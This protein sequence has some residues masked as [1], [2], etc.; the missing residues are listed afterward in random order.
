MADGLLR[1]SPKSVGIHCVCVLNSL[2]DKILIHGRGGKHSSPKIDLSFDP[3][4]CLLVVDLWTVG[5][6]VLI[7]LY[8]LFPLPKI[9]SHPSSCICRQDKQSLTQ[10][11]NTESCP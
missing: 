6:F 5:S 10:G 1:M 9:K 11:Q 7:L 8:D 4:L 3:F 2:S